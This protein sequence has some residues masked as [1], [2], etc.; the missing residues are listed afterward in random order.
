MAPVVWKPGPGV[1]SMAISRPLKPTSRP[2][3]GS[4]GEVRMK[5]PLL[6]FGLILKSRASTKS[7]RGFS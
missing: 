4:S 2:G 1:A 5:I 7:P 6:H 3:R